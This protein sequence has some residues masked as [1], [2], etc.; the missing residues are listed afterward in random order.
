MAPAAAPPHRRPARWPDRQGAGHLASPRPGRR[1]P[2]GPPLRPSARGRRRRAG[3]RAFTEAWRPRSPEEAPRCPRGRPDGSSSFVWLRSP[4]PRR[5]RPRPTPATAA[6][7]GQRRP[8][9]SSSPPPPSAQP[10]PPGRARP[11]HLQRALG[12][13]RARV[14]GVHGASRRRAPGSQQ[15]RPGPTARRS[16]SRV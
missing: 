14:S 5:P 12:A 10:T 8:A 3:G 13:E 6:A 2:P 9:V 1:L 7:G 4:E 16:H 15:P 11:S